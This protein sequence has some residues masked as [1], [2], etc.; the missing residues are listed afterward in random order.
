MERRA[1]QKKGEIDHQNTEIEEQMLQ[2][3]TEME[4]QMLPKG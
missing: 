3:R 4:Q 2:Q 1:L